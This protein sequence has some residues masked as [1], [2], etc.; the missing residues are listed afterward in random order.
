MS[1]HEHAVCQ[2]I[3]AAMEAAPESPSV[4]LFKLYDLYKLN[5]EALQ[6]AL[7]TEDDI[8]AFLKGV[9]DSTIRKI[10]LKLVPD[11]IEQRMHDVLWLAL[12][13]AVRSTIPG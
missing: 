8:V 13:Q 3:E 4:R 2:G 7:P 11:I 9:Y 6:A 12:E 10:N 5:R 1:H